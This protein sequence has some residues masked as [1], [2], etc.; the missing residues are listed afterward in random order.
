MVRGLHVRLPC[1]P[2][3][4][5]ERAH[6]TIKV[7]RVL[8]QRFGG[9]GGLLNYRGILLH[10]LIH[11]A[12][13]VVDLF[14]AARLFPRCHADLVDDAGHFFHRH[15]NIVHCLAGILNLPRASLNL[16]HG[17]PDQHLD[18]LGRI[19]GPLREPANFGGDHRKTAALLARPRG[20]DGSIQGEDVGLER[21]AIDDAND[22]AD[23]L[24][25]LLDFRS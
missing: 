23:L 11:L 8:M 19:G 13:G 2:I 17:I 12:H 1:S 3:A 21:D 6:R 14:D 25:T 18:F 15:N 22:V 4:E 20:L 7:L 5:L 9:G 10:H 16:L 24:R